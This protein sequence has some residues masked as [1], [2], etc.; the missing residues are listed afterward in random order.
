[1]QYG[2]DTE[3]DF[4]IKKLSE[5]NRDTKMVDFNINMLY[6]IAIE[7]KQDYLEEQER[8]HEIINNIEPEPF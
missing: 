5:Y 2:T 4:F 7:A 8:I 3:F 1:M 6:D